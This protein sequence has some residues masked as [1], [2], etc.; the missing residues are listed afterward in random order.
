MPDTNEDVVVRQIPTQIKTKQSWVPNDT[1]TVTST[2]GNLAAGGTVAFSLYADNAI[3]GRR[4][5]H[6]DARRPRRQPVGGGGHQQH[7][8]RQRVHDHHRLH[9]RPDS[10][11]GPYSW[12]VVY[13]PAASDTAHKGKQSSCDAEHFS[14]KYTNDPGPNTSP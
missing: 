13:T 9:R 7:R 12:K 2:I 10:T 14:T 11:K 6:R 5:V 4:A 1:A 8:R 3:F